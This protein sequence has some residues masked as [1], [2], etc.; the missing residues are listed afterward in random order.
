[1]VERTAFVSLAHN[2]FQI[3]L[4]ARRQRKELLTSRMHFTELWLTVS[5]PTESF[6][7]VSV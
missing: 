6:V 5:L 2:S 7:S 3:A 4:T 1:M